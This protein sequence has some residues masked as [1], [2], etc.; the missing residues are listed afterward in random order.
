MVRLHK[1]ASPEDRIDNEVG[2]VWQS[3]TSFDLIMSSPIRLHLEITGHAEIRFFYSLRTQVTRYQKTWCYH[4]LQYC[5]SH[6]RSLPTSFIHCT[7]RLDRGFVSVSRVKNG[8]LRN[9]AAIKPEGA[10]KKI[11]L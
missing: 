9:K 2:S 11:S 3:M 1:N 5:M 4:M 7:L 6:S 8:K 10:V